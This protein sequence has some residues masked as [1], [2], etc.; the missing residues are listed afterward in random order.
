MQQ[1]I[2]KRLTFRLSFPTRAQAVQLEHEVIDIYQRRIEQLLDECL[3]KLTGPGTDY[4]ID[5]L[6][7]DLGRIKPENL[8]SE[9]PL[10]FAEQLRKNTDNGRIRAAGIISER[11]KQLT[12]FRRFIET[13][14]L[15]W[16]AGRVDKQALE[17]LLDKLCVNS[18]KEIRGIV[19]GILNDG[20][21]IRRLVNQLSDDCLSRITALYLSGRDVELIILLFRDTEA[22]IAELDRQDKVRGIH[23][24][25]QSSAVDTEFRETQYGE[26]GTSSAGTDRQNR[27]RRVH[28]PRRL[29]AIDTHPGR[30]KLR[31]HYWRT[32]LFILVYGSSGEFSTGTLLQET[33]VS[34]TSNNIDAYR[35]LLDRVA[36]A[37]ES[38]AHRQ[39]RFD[40]DV[41]DLIEQFISAATPEAEGSA[42]IQAS[43]PPP[44]EYAVVA[45]TEKVVSLAAKIMRGNER[46]LMKDTQKISVRA[47]EAEKAE[48]NSAQDT[49][50]DTDE[51][52]IHNAGLVIL[53]PYLAGL[54]L[55][56][57]LADENNFIDA[58]AAERAALLLQ[59]LVEPDTEMPESLLSLNKLL[60][61]LE[62][63]RPIPAEFT[64]TKREGSECGALLGAVRHHWDVLQNMSDERVRSD[65]LQRQGILRP[66]AGNWQLQV[67]HQAHDILMQKLPWPIGVI[68]LPWMDFA[69]LV[70]WS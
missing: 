19:Q 49:F 31:E 69:L 33:L 16:W 17:Q 5:K 51:D 2:I 23:T 67:E 60:C 45:E 28:T 34:L 40:T 39:H 20:V 50:T 64:P 32:V 25:R 18:P 35:R 54:F 41:P 29:S 26:A 15:P 22:L 9:M 57:G 30:I 48:P 43:K 62:L 44:A 24:S 37:A 36:D 53:W 59:Y 47:Q 63:N 11:E 58:D 70:H 52:Y 13:G 21:K 6:E 3:S 4:Q 10:R 61:G 55:N 14:R 7:L 42:A 56:L 1:H 8:Q 66:C 12:L 38:L 27:N 46:F 65:F 68:K